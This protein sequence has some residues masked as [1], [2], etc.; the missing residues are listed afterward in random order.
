MSSVGVVKFL[1]EQLAYFEAVA[2]CANV[3]PEMVRDLGGKFAANFRAKVAMLRALGP[4][5]A[6]GLV[7]KLK[8]SHLPG[9]QALACIELLNQAVHARPIANGCLAMPALHRPL[10]SPPRSR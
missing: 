7:V 4:D 10:H 8:E 6:L 9:D 3:P 2:T 5:V 1:D